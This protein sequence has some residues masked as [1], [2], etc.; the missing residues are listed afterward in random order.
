MTEVMDTLDSRDF[1]ACIFVGPAQTG[2]TD[3]LIL[4]WILHTV[5]C[6]PADFILY[7]TSQSVARDFSRR[8][9]DRLHR[10]SPAVGSQ[11]MKAGDADNTHDKYYKSGIILTLSWPTI[12][13]LSGR[14]VGRV[15][16]TDYDR[17]TQDVDGEGSPFDLGNKRTT[18]FG[19]FAMTLAESSPGFETTNPKWMP[20]PKA[21]HE[22]PPCPGIL[23]LYN[24]GDRRRWHWQCPSCSDWFEPSFKLLKFDVGQKDIT[25]AADAVTMICPCCG[26]YET[27]K[28]DMQSDL[29]RRG[30]WL[31]EGQTIDK[32]GVVHGEGRKSDIA[33]FWMKGPAASFTSWPKLVLK[34][35]Q[36]EA[37]FS[38]TGSQEALKST[39][40]TDQGEPYI[41]RGFG[42]SRLPEDIKAK[43]LD[44]P[45]KHVPADVRCLL[46]TI[47]VQGTSFQVQVHGVEPG[48][49][50]VVIDRFSIQKSKRVDDDGD[51]LW[52]KPGSYAEDWELITEEVLQKTYPL[53][54]GSGRRMQIKM[55]GCDSGGKEGVTAKAYD[56]YRSLKKRGMAGR[57]QLL[58]GGSTPAAPRIM[59]SYPDSQRK[60]RK[61]AARGEIPVLMLN[62]DK[63]KD[64]LDNMLDRVDAGGGLIRFPD[65]L[66]DSFFVELTVEQ[67]DHKGKWQN[68]KKLRNESWDLLAYCLALVSHLNME[69][70]NWQKPPTW[71]A[72]WDAN[73]LV[74]QPDT[75]RFGT[76]P[77][78]KVDLSRL[79][80]D[81]A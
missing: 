80:A 5:V 43:A 35:L 29:N 48:L 20:D 67:K 28:P 55:V 34:Y 70:I 73:T 39:T 81:L 45:E 53:D 19:S 59:L 65:W 41:P 16:F 69:Q 15:A 47:D 68:P 32:K 36:A 24:R 75:P 11:L 46:A 50:L 25:K 37:E 7:Q 52:V 61:A 74:S 4:N 33:S 3:S 54:D 72:T 12:N 14:P 66:P 49:D 40:N 21:K 22:A 38:A 27:M 62:T 57:F 1:N 77:K 71:V 58:K 8:R 79:A 26:D 56:Y 6:S 30:R 18:T 31:K 10:H 42:S 17:M 63:L 78:P 51:K 44:I 64:Q 9:V 23:S 2:K 76:T 13:E 60:D